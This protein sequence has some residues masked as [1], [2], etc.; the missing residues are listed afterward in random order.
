KHPAI[1]H[2]S[3][4]FAMRLSP[5]NYVEPR[6]IHPGV[7]AV[8]SYRS[9][10]DRVDPP[11]LSSHRQVLSTSDLKPPAF[12]AQK[13]GL[14]AVGTAAWSPWLSALAFSAQTTSGH[15]PSGRR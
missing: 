8:R 10:R 13:S 12:P 3:P 6:A 11:R 7:T 4:P 14:S 1:T 9:S 2:D 5:Q 15:C